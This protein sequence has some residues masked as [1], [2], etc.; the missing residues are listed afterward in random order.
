MKFVPKEPDPQRNP[1]VSR[2]HPLREA[3]TLV[4]G[5][6]LLVGVCSALIALAV[7]FVVLWIPPETEAKLGWVDWTEDQAR[8]DEEAVPIQ[9]LVD[10]LAEGWP[11][12]PYRFRVVILDGE[13]PNAF[14]F[15]GGTIG[16]TRG[17]LDEVESMNELA[18]VPQHE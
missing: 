12:N 9:A 15:P 6:I 8:A 17:L 7:D 3:L 4:V 11:E 1:N 5:T 13:A 2:E 14:A 18:F 10:R 16:V